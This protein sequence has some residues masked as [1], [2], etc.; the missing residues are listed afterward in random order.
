MF[1]EK[2]MFYIIIATI[3]IIM[4]I[5]I[6]MN[7]NAEEIKIKDI[8]KTQQRAI[9]KVET[10]CTDRQVPIYN[11]QQS[12]DG[13]SILGTIIGGVAGGLLGSTV[14]KGTGKSVA[15]GGG[16]V[17]GALAGNQVGKNMGSSNDVVGY[18]NVQQCTPHTTYDY[19]NEEIY[20]HS[21]I[22]FWYNGQY[23]TLTFIK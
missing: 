18:Q 5:L 14:G 10:V 2:H 13:S 11:N 9:P 15:I 16:A 19:V 21:E 1:K 22:T 7:V 17:A 12:S 8:Y 20:S 4:T 3:A 23:K 6:P